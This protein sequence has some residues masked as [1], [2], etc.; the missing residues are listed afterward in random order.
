MYLLMHVEAPEDYDQQ[1]TAWKDRKGYPQDV[2][3]L[4]LMTFK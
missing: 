3:I 2:E 4:F 1:K